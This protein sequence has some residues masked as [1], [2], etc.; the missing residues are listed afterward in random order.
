VLR[1][2]RA[3]GVTAPVLMLTAKSQTSS[4]VSALDAGADDYL[5]KP[6]D[7]SELLARVRALVRRRGSNWDTAAP[8]A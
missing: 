6:F 7:V 5:T 4:K 2:A 1:R 8:Q 3:A